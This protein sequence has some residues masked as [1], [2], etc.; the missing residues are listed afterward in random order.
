VRGTPVG[1]AGEVVAAAA[2]VVAAAAHGC[3]CLRSYWIVTRRGYPS[4]ARVLRWTG[5][6]LGEVDHRLMLAHKEHPCIFRLHQNQEEINFNIA[7]AP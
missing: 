4:R 7:N 3:L 6:L 5:S 1:V 2:A